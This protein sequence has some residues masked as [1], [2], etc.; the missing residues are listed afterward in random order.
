MNLKGKSNGQVC[1]GGITPNV[2]QLGDVA[3]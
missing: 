2:L 1:R 3:D